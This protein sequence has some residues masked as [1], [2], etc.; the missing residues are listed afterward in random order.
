MAVW[1]PDELDRIG[2][3]TE[4]RIASRRADGTLRRETTI[5]HVRSGDDLYVRSAHGPQNGWF[6]AAKAAG[7][8]SVSAGGVDKDVTFE[9]ADPAVRDALDA[10][11]HAKYDRYG[12]SPVAAVTGPDVLETTLRVVPQG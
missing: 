1:T 10:A 2:G 3:A 4:L 8:G 5:W 7:S 11:Y 6:R 12:P 9:P